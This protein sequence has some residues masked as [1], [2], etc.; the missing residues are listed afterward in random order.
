MILKCFGQSMTYPYQGTKFRLLAHRHLRFMPQGRLLGFNMQ[1]GQ[2]VMT[3]LK[4]SVPT[5]KARTTG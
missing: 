5:R 2:P 1:T 3:L 4:L